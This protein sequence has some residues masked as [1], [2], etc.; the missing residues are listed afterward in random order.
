MSH[1]RRARRA[2]Q[3]EEDASKLKFG[4][5]F[6]GEE[7]L[8]ISEVHL[9]LQKT[10]ENQKNTP[11]LMRHKLHKY[12]LVQLANL[13]CDEVEEAKSLIPRK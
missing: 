1:N 6:E 12:E 13:C 3:E 8:F 4:E 5:D 11:T 10:P 7:F 9:L 2:P